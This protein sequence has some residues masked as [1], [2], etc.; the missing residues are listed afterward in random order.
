M[1]A[2]AA[3]RLSPSIFPASIGQSTVS[4]VLMR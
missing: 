1:G 2:I 4:I 3:E